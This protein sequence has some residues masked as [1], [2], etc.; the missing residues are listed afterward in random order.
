VPLTKG[1]ESFFVMPDNPRG[2][3]LKKIKKR[4]RK[5]LNRKIAWQK[6][7]EPNITD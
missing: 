4:F 7:G 5:K 1:I 6:G 2:K 3:N